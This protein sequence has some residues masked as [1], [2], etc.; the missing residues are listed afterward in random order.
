MTR[1]ADALMADENGMVTRTSIGVYADYLM[2][3]GTDELA[4]E[5][6]SL[7]LNNPEHPSIPELYRELGIDPKGTKE[8][9]KESMVR[10]SYPLVLGVLSDPLARWF[11]TLRVSSNNVRDPQV[12]HEWENNPIT[13]VTITGVRRDFDF[14]D[15]RIRHCSDVTL[16][17]VQLGAATL[18]GKLLRV[19]PWGCEYLRINIPQD[20]CQLVFE[21][22]RGHRNPWENL[23]GV[24]SDNTV[25]L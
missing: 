15:G 7:Q 4:G 25:Q 23:K 14:S 21:R 8:I 13:H 18:L 3:S 2:E 20:Y 5:L 24:I 9:V 19:E 16:E 1:T 12:C 17:L 11:T 22:L 10:R 6:I